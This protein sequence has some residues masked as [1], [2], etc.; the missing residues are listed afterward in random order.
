MPGPRSASMPDPPLVAGPAGVER[1]ILP[2]CDRWAGW[3]TDCA[4]QV[5]SDL[6][7]Y[8]RCVLAAVPVAGLI[9]AT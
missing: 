9:A 3:L 5:Q 8:R 7:L 6:H 2:A 4:R 1:Y